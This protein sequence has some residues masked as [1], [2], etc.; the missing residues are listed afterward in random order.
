MRLTD[1]FIQSFQSREMRKMDRENLAHFFLSEKKIFKDH[2]V[3]SIN[4]NLSI[5]CTFL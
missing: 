2:D 1:K 3:N 5:F 4:A